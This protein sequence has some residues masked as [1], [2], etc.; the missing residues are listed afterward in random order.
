V[1]CVLKIFPGLAQALRLVGSDHLV[2]EAEPVRQA[3]VAGHPEAVE[4]V[5][6]EEDNFLVN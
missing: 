4:V 2:V 5:V 6:E 3:A 1:K